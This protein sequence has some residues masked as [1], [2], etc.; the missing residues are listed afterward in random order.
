MKI[1][2]AGGTG[3]LG[4]LLEKTFLEKNHQVYVISRK[5]S[6]NSNHIQWDSKNLGE[7]TREIENADVV[8]NLAGRSVTCRYTKK[9]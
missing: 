7:W 4:K 1:I 2:L 6:K 3:Q 9:T 8:I 5:S